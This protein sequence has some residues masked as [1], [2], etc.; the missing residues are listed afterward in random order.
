[1]NEAGE[2]LLYQ[3]ED[4][5]TR[6]ECRFIDDTLWLSQALMAEL[7]QVPVPA[8]NEHLKATYADGELRPE[9]TI[10]K[11]RIVRSEGARQVARQ[12]DHNNLDAI[13]AVGYRVPSARGTQ[14]RRW[15]SE[16]LMLQVPE[17]DE[18]G[19]EEL[20]LRISSRRKGGKDV[21]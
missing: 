14:S 16:R 11:F 5:R 7:S 12:I 15:A 18:A 2:F 20:G 19:V 9:P 21:A 6:V 8:I 1:M 4:G 3:T 10:R 13:L 17:A